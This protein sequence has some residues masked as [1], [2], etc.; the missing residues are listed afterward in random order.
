MGSAGNGELPC[1]DDSRGETRASGPRTAWHGVCQM[2]NIM[3]LL[4]G[5]CVFLVV[6]TATARA[7]TAQLDVPQEPGAPLSP[8][9]PAA[10]AA[11][12]TLSAGGSSRGLAGC[13]S[14]SMEK[15]P[16]V[17]SLRM[18]GKSELDILGPTP[19][20]KVTDYGVLLGGVARGRYVS[21]SA[22]FGVSMFDSVR[23]GKLLSDGGD[24]IMCSGTYEAV[25]KTG[26]GIP[27][28]ATLTFHG[29]YAGGGLSLFGNAN[30]AFSYV[31]VGL[32][33]S[34]GILR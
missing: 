33:F 9:K 12:V 31:G 21:L 16:L 25:R 2:W 14:A 34:G 32:S 22:E 28:A 8:E 27:F 23:R 20:E 13:A 24:C 11:Y 6:A 3:R 4:L 5:S 10:S 30:Q 15:G 19:A 1:P 17:V 7:H 26:V 29:A 18:A